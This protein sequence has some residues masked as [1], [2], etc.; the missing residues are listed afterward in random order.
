MFCND[1]KSLYPTILQLNLSHE[2]IVNNDNYDN[3]D[4]EYYTLNIKII[5]EQNNLLEL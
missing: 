4:I 3:M 2:T 5:K 1:L